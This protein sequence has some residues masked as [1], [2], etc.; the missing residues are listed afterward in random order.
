[1]NGGLSKRGILHY[2]VPISNDGSWQRSVHLLLGLE[3][4]VRALHEPL[5]EIVIYGSR[6][7]VLFDPLVM[8]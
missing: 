3:Q 2:E 4:G 7:A 8:A 6:S 1:M 5:C